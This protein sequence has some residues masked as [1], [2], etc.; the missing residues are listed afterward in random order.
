VLDSWFSW[1]K[2]SKNTNMESP[3]PNINLHVADDS[4]FVGVRMKTEKDRDFIERAQ[5][6]K[7]SVREK[8]RPVPSSCVV[9]SIG[10]RPTMEDIHVCKVF[11]FLFESFLLFLVFKKN[12]NNEYKTSR[13]LL[14]CLKARWRCRTCRF[15]QFTMGTVARNARSFWGNVCSKK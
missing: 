14:F 6:R 10:K 1:S 7:M 11:V 13:M 8:M 3:F 5:Q 9:E 12:N 4:P 15:M 2:F